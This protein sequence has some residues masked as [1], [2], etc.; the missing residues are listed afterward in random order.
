M[1]YLVS[2]FDNKHHSLD[3]E[4]RGEGYPTEIEGTARLLD[5]LAATQ[6]GILHNWDTETHTTKRVAYW[7]IRVSG[8]PRE[9]YVTA[10]G[11]TPGTQP[12]GVSHQTSSP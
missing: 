9:I 4:A 3:T 12:D 7:V 5:F 6:T 11:P 2:G 10:W 8:T 1:T